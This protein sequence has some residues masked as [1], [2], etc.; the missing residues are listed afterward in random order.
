MN[1]IQKKFFCFVFS[2][3]LVSQYCSYVFVFNIPYFSTAQYLENIW[4]MESH[5]KVTANGH[6]TAYSIYS[7]VGFY[8]F[9]MF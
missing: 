6:Y 2:F 1:K 7:S 3:P 5:V 9:F 8:L 4:K